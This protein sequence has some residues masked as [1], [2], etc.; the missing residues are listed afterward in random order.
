MSI[1]HEQAVAAVVRAAVRLAGTPRNPHDL[2]ANSDAARMLTGQVRDHVVAHADPT[3]A[4]LWCAH[5]AD[6]LAGGASLVWTPRLGATDG[7][8]CL[9]DL[10]AFNAARDRDPSCDLCGAPEGA[11]GA[12]TAVGPVAAQA[13]LCP[14]C[15]RRRTSARI[16]RG[17][18]DTV[19]AILASRLAC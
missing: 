5:A 17:A 4:G 15:W 13:V 9:V 19:S 11:T 6:V 2:P 12:I 14:P 3:D 18:A 8:A 7:L 16:D 10:V 1:S